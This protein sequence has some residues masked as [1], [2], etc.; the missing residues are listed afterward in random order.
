MVPVTERLN[1]FEH[2]ILKVHLRGCQY[3]SLSEPT[4]PR[5]AQQQDSLLLSSSP[6][7]N[8]AL[9]VF[10]VTNLTIRS[11]ILPACLS[12]GA[13]NSILYP[14]CATNS[15]KSSEVY[16]ASESIRIKRGLSGSGFAASYTA[17]VGFEFHNVVNALISSSDGLQLQ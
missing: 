14:L 16:A 12:R 4:L 13:V 11:A 5:R 3:Y 8:I 17:Q 6:L 9:L 15:K 7:S 2:W 1:N 10:E